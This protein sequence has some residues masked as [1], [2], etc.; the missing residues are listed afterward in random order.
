MTKLYEPPPVFELPLSKGGDVYFAIVYKPLLV[1]EDGQPVLDDY[2]RRQYVEADY[3]AG[4]S[5]QVVIE[6]SPELPNVVIDGDIT[7]S[8]AIIWGDYTDTDG[9]KPGK[10]WRAVITYADG[11][12]KVLCNGK[13]TRFDGG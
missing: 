8:T 7:G 3:P 10:L 5:V 2:D 1:D 9:V 12:D 6:T 11:L 13:I 4:A